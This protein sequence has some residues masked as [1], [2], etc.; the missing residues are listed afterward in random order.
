MMGVPSV[1]VTLC[2]AAPSPGCLLYIRQHRYSFLQEAPAPTLYTGK[3]VFALAFC[4]Y[5]CCALQLPGHLS[6]FLIVL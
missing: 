4:P 2:L 3:A 6:F 5:L 1:S